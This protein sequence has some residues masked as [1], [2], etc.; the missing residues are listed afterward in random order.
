M[1]VLVVTGGIGSGKSLVC[2]IL[3]KS[4]LHWQYDSDARVKALYGENPRILDEIE[5]SLGQKFRDDA[6]NLIPE[7]LAGRIF[8]DPEA[9]HTVEGI[10]FEALAADFRSFLS[11]AEAEGGTKWVVFESAT[12]LEKEFFAG[13][14]DMVLLVDAPVRKRIERAVSRDSSSEE[15][16]VS[17]MSRQPL[18]NAISEGGRD[19]RIDYVMENDGDVTE[20]EEKVTAFYH[21]YLSN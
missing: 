8:T 17:R 18:M 15:S 12:V 4:G 1:K 14:G 21:K 3:R 10:V 16:V 5:R 13:F 6:G 20:L 2:S 11:M 7:L 9:M 19:P